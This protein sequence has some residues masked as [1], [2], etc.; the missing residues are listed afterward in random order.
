MTQVIIDD[1]VPR[2]QLVASAGQTVFNTNWTANAASDVLVYARADGVEPDDET[3]LVSTTDYNVTFIGGSQTVRVTF[4]SG[5][6]LDDVITIVRNTPSE[7]MNLYINTNFVP[8]MLNEDFGILTLVDQQAQ[9]YDTVINPRYNVSATIEPDSMLGG[10]DIVLPILPPGFGWRKSLDGTKIEAIAIPDGGFAPQVG[11][12]VTIDDERSTMPNSF[13][14]SDLG[15]SS[16]AGMGIPA[17]TTA[18]RVIPTP[19]NIGLRFNTDLSIIEA[20]IGGNWVEIPSSSAGLFLPLAGGTMTGDIDMDTNRID[21]LPVPLTANQAATK[22][23]VDGI[24]FNTHPACNVATTSNLA[25]YTYDNGASGVGATLTAGSNGA[26]SA[27]GQSPVLGARIFVSFQTDQ[28]ENGIYTLSQV[29]D[30]STPAILTRASDFDTSD[31]MHAGDEVAV[32][33][34][35]TFA[36]SK[37]MMTQT[38]TIVV[39]TTAI[40][41][42]DISVPSNV[43]TIDGTQTITGDK[44]FTGAVEVPTPATDDEAVPKSYV[45]VRAGFTEIIVNVAD[46]PYTWNKPAAFTADSF[47]TIEVSG[48]GGS[49]GSISATGAGQAAC[50]SSAGAGGYAYKKIMAND[51]GATETVTIGAGAAAPAAG[52]NSGSPGGTSSFGAHVSCTGGSGGSGSAASSVYTGGGGGSG[53]VATGGDINIRGGRGGGRRTT[54]GLPFPFSGGGSNPLGSSNFSS[55]T[56]GADGIIFGGGGCGA[57]AGENMS[58]RAGGAGADGVVII[59]EYI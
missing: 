23:Y 15:N 19:P 56:A 12:F 4:L 49:G 32:I 34:G 20:Y 50:A 16:T 24:A 30:G 28:A 46:S 18:Q 31:D 53:G 7:R 14:L 1:I 9:M 41:W 37:W 42:I 33:A 21:G 13:P 17:G 2:T 51:L 47:I 3:Q 27:D 59:R 54:G 45:D 44:T 6:T 57:A 39:G 25:G 10:G 5:R 48:G 8:S 26:F 52:N 11:S 40:T 22:G 36:G 29:G 58:A 43:V 55:T 35:N 38:A